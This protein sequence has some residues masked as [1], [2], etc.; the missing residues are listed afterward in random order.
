[1]V[2]LI[3]LL[4]GLI[5]GSFVN[6]FVWRAHEHKD[7]VRG[8]S[9]CSVCHHQLGVWDLIPVVSWV[10]LRGRC[11]YCKRPIQ[12]GPLVEL[13]VPALFIVSYIW[14]PY[15]LH[16]TGLVQFIFWLVFLIGY[17]ILVVYDLRWRLLPNKVVYPLIALAGIEVVVLHLILSLDVRAI[18]SAVAAVLVL[19]G[20]FYV[21]FQVSAGKWIGGGDVKL[22]VVLGLLAG[23]P[24]RALLLLFIASLSGTMLALPLLARGKSSAKLVIPFGPFLILAAVIVQLF[25]GGIISWYT[26]LV[27]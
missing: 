1:M 6:A 5:W 14:W 8:R 16:G 3:L 24:L 25:G 27:I 17:A 4:L 10:V 9:E 22:A 23:D 13:L 26:H 19:S 15:A 7:W 20:T 2:I 21:L 12:D 18:L 11:R